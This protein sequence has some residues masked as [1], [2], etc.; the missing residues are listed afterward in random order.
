MDVRLCGAEPRRILTQLDDLVGAVLCEELREVDAKL[1]EASEV[2]L[3]NLVEE[4][5]GFGALLGLGEL[6]LTK[7]LLGF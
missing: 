7:E 1:G 6:L 2:F 5:F 3:L 4:A